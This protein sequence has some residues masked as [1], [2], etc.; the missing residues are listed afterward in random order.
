VHHRSLMILL[1]GAPA[2]AAQ[3]AGPPVAPKRA[4]ADTYQH[5][6]VSDDYRWLEDTASPETRAWAAAQN[7]WTR[8]VLDA[9]PSRRAIESRVRQIVR[10]TSPA[11]FKLQRRGNRWFALKN[12]WAKNQPMLVTLASLDQPRSERILLDPNT[13]EPSGKTAIDFYE[14]SDN[15]RWVAVS[16]S[17]GGTE[18]GDVHVYDG[19]TGR[20]QPRDIIPRVNGGTAGG[21]VAWTHDGSGFFYTRY[22]R[23]TERP[24]EDQAFFQQVWFHRRGTT[25]DSD[26]YEVGHDF[27]RIGETTLETSPDGHWVLAS[28]R[29]GDGGDVMHHL[30]ASSGAWSQLAAFEDQIREAHFGLDNQLYLRSLKGAEKGQILRLVP[31][32]PLAKATVAAPEGEASIAEFVATRTRLYVAGV[33]GGPVQVRAYDQR[34]TALGAL[35]LPPVADASELTRTQRGDDLYLAVTEYTRP[36]AWYRVS[37][38]GRRIVPTRLRVRAPVDLNSVEVIRDTAVSKDGTRVPMT[39]MRAKGVPQ[40]GTAPAILTGYGG[41]AISSTPRFLGPDAAWIE[42]GGIIVQANIRGGSEFGEAWHE[43]GKLTHKQNVFDDFQACARILVEKKYVSPGRLGIEGGSNGGLLMGAALTQAPNLYRAVVSHV[44]IYDMLRNERTSNGT[45]NITEYGSTKDLDQFHALASYSPYHRVVS[46]TPYPSI[47]L[48]TGLNDPRV[49]PWQSFKMT[50]RLQ[51][52]TSSKNPVLL[53]VAET[54]HGFGSSIEDKIALETDSLAFFFS[55][56]GLPYKP[57]TEPAR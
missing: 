44:G 24:L 57:A 49:D 46:S 30:R 33:V 25:T 26:L 54:G 20:E 15:G 14:A 55:E 10:G 34:G 37:E 39:I 56:L 7:A 9:V 32:Q 8:T 40:D 36:R 45:F 21:S 29:N 11:H 16:L 18:S 28:T 4:V 12:D 23:G 31:G 13:L 1:A 5:A 43:A 48:S 53:R 42:Q 51:A 52:A 35:A 41:F 47:L 3:P 17:Q 38:G 22:P 19:A 27:P 6:Q 50:A 2:L